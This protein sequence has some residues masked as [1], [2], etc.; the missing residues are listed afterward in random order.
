M[1]Y[2]K[3]FYY[4][5]LSIKEYIHNIRIL[6]FLIFYVYLCISF[7]LRNTSTVDILEPMKYGI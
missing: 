2:V 4:T 3:P 5:L 7:N 6:I 1:K